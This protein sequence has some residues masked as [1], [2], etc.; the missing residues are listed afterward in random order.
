MIVPSFF[1]VVFDIMKFQI[2]CK[3]NEVIYLCRIGHNVL[4][5]V[6]TFYFEG[7][8]LTC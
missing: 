2:T 6:R 8:M 7:T 4:A 5:M 3:N 1:C